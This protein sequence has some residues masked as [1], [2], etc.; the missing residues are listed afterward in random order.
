MN[1]ELSKPQ[2]RLL[3][4]AEALFAERGFEA[5]SLRDIT[6]EAGA[7]VAAVNYH[8][9]GKENLIGAVLGLSLIH[10]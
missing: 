4:A 7:N 3:D 5:V 6:L 9:G 1:G 8:F 10:I 2:E